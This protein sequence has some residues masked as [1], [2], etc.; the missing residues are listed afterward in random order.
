MTQHALRKT[1][2]TPLPR[3]ETAEEALSLCDRLMEVTADLISVLERETALL[4]KAKVQDL[5]ALHVRKQSLSAALHRDLELLR[6]NADF[7]K[8]A[9]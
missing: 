5:T 6:R 8:M 1:Q 2:E 7:V 4:R 9:T 3:I